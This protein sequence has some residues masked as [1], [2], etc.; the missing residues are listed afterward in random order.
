[1]PSI[2]SVSTGLN[3]A[4]ICLFLDVDGTLLDLVK[5][6]EQVRVPRPLVANLDRL[7][8]RLEGALALVSGRPI[9]QLDALF[10]PL[11]L[12]AS[13]VHGYELRP[14]GQALRRRDCSLDALGRIRRDVEEL[15]AGFDGARMEY[16]PSAVAVHYRERPEAEDSLRA[17]MQMLAERHGE[18]VALIDGDQVLEL[19]PRGCSKAGAIDEFMAIAPFRDR[20]P[21][22]LGDDTTD[23]GAFETVRR[24][25]GVDV[26][27]GNRVTARWHLAS[28]TEVRRWIAGLADDTTV[29]A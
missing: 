23:F 22:Y 12:P 2:P 20:Q 25:D 26:A 3:L 8:R 24:Y 16:K 10:R 4:H 19:V 6:P 1:M 14:S 13:G 18:E 7:L 27:V 17:G 29:K 11:R 9:A 21:F 15:V 5:T 28:P